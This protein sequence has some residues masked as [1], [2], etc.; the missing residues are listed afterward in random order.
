MALSEEKQLLYKNYEHEIKVQNIVH[1]KELK[2]LLNTIFGIDHNQM[3]ECKIWKES[4][5]SI[6]SIRFLDVIRQRKSQVHYKMTIHFA[7]FM[8][9][10]TNGNS[11]RIKDLYVRFY[12]DGDLKI[13][14]SD[15]PGHR[16]SDY[17]L[18]GLRTTFTREEY[19]ASYAHSHLP[20]R[21]LTFM[22]FCT[23]SGPIN[24]DIPLLRRG[25]ASN[26]MKIFLN[27]INLYVRHESLEGNPHM[28]L[29]RIGTSN[30]TLPNVNYSDADFR[31]FFDLVHG[32]FMSNYKQLNFNLTDTGIT[33]ESTDEFSIGMA[34]TIAALFQS[35]TPDI[36]ELLRYRSVPELTPIRNSDGRYSAVVLPSTATN[37]NTR[38]LIDFKGQ[39]KTLYIGNDTELPTRGVGARFTHP[40][41]LERFCNIYAGILTTAAIKLQ[42]PSW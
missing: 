30:I 3:S 33:V 29:E 42:N 40:Q 24:Q 6:P 35:P 37:T 10:N 23:G 5:E 17:Y 14:T 18:T 41:L 28:Y 8:I 38:T 2:G 25:Y 21:D 27:R 7:D 12:L 11:Q 19:D 32:C 36:N 13:C 15:E 1:L 31:K 9:T 22:K 4:D 34:V 20:G 16:G 39:L 26:N